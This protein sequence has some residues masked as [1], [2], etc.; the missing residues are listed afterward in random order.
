MP[1]GRGLAAVS[2]SLRCRAGDRAQAEPCPVPRPPAGVN[3]HRVSG[4]RGSLG[5][6]WEAE[7][8]WGRK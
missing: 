4:H 2:G 1:G 3:A 6:H 5:Q 7:R 8:S